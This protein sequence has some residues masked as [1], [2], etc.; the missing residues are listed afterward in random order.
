MSKSARREALIFYLCISPFILG[1]VLFDLVPMVASLVLSFTEWNILSPPHFIGL[2]NYIT[3]FTLDPKVGISLKVTLK[4]TIVAVPL[5]LTIAL[6]L[7]ILLNEATKGV[8]FFR[9]AFY[10]PAIVSSVAIAV[11]WTWILNPVY[12]PVNG[13]LRVFGIHGPQWLTDPKFA[14]WGLILMSGWGVGG[15][16][17][18]FLAGLKGIDKQLYEAAELDGAGRVPRFFR[19]TIP[20]LSATIFFNLVLSIIGSFQTFDTAYV[21]STAHAGTLGGPSNSTLFYMLYLYNRAFAGQ[22]MGYASAL[23]WILF[24]IIMVITLFVLRSSDL[25]VF[26]EAGRRR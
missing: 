25:W 7:A 5:K 15:E 10:L 13:L 16:M 21:L 12:G 26:Y 11:L 8:N 6:M 14:L 18:I 1:I 2:Q 24:A 4:Y 9:T 19:I 23:G 20:M 3:A 22:M 17:L